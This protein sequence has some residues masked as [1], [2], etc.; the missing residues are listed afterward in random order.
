MFQQWLGCGPKT[1]QF[2]SLSPL[3]ARRSKWRLI[4][5]RPCYPQ[6]GA[7]GKAGGWDFRD[8]FGGGFHGQNWG[9]KFLKRMD[10]NGKSHENGWF[11]GTLISGNHHLWRSLE[12][13]RWNINE[14]WITR[15]GVYPEAAIW[16][17]DL[18]WTNGFLGTVPYTLW[19]SH[20]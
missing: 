14:S 19:Q 20:I 6:A 5:W 9:T 7:S 15:D 18:L 17:G 1:S 4:S 11:G 10:C 8:R 2:R 13:R 16:E 12:S 3:F